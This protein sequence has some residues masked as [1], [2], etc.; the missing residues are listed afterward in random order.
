LVKSQLSKNLSPDQPDHIKRK[1]LE[2]GSSVN[3]S[4]AETILPHPGSEEI[5]IKPGLVL[6]KVKQVTPFVNPEQVNI[7]LDD[8]QKD[9]NESTPND[10]I[11]AKPRIIRRLVPRLKKI[12]GI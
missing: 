2:P 4:D 11:I 5:Q 3:T 1:E 8:K 6:D 7:N 9:Q 10:P 12:F